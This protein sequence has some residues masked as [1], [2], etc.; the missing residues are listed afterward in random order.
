M[1]KLL[2]IQEKKGELERQRN[3]KHK[4]LKESGRKRI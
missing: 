1:E 4:V 2:R 3:V